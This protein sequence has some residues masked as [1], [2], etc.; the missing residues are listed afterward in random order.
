MSRMM[1]EAIN[2]WSRPLHCYFAA[3]YLSWTGAHR[4]VVCCRPSRLMPARLSL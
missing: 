2:G 3:E 1:R 4:P